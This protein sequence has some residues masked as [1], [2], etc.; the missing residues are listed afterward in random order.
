MDTR[1]W[2][3]P[4]CVVVP[5]VC[6]WPTC[7]PGGTHHGPGCQAPSL[8]RLPENPLQLPGVGP[9]AS[10][11]LPG[12]TA[13]TQESRRADVGWGVSPQ[14][15]DTSIQPVWHPG[16]QGGIPSATHDHPPIPA[17]LG[18]TQ[19]LEDALR[20]KAPEPPP[21]D[22]AVGDPVRPEEGVS[23]HLRA[24]SRP[25]GTYPMPTV[26]LRLWGLL[27]RLSCLNCA[28]SHPADVL[29]TGGQ[30]I[31]RPGLGWAGLGFRQG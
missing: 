11:A 18:A 16:S 5:G 24:T 7:S 23:S 21:P 17:G 2:S 13:E 27:Q 30:G 25:G 28:Q 14:S 31:R 20:P 10:P 4:E 1:A 29:A 26:A 3:L 19:N 22:R 8:L 9:P 12:A 15:Q 6:P